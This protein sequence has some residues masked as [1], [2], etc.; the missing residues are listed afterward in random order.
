MSQNQGLELSHDVL[1][2][3]AQLA[4]DG[5]EGVRTISPP[6]RVGEFLTGRRAKGIQIERVDDQVDIALT[7]AMTYGERIPRVATAVQRAVREAVGSMTGLEVRSVDVFVEAID[8]PT[9]APGTP[10]APVRARGKR[11]SSEAAAGAAK[12]STKRSSAKPEDPPRG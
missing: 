1:Y 5:V 12:G 9:P 6:T 10:G 4:L 3:I 2:G 11:P 7:V 8:V